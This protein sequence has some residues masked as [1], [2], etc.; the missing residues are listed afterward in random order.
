MEIR[1]AEE[2]DLPE[3]LAIYNYEV[4][5]GVATFDTAPASL[6]GRRA[7]LLAH[8]R[9]NHPL[10]V[11]VREGRVAGYVSLS[12]FSAKPAYSGTVEL[13]IYIAP[14]ARGQGVGRALMACIIDEARRDP[15]THAIISI[16][17]AG[18]EASIRLHEGF[19][20]T[21]CGTLREVGDKF[22]RILDVNYYELLV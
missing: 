4:A 11:A 16:I 8:N 6:P 18:N 3:L 15:R 21:H 17:T 13:S 7:W 14:D 9:D 20:F 12:T 5:N 19:G 22:G 1:I 2:R 10:F